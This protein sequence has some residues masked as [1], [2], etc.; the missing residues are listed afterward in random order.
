[1]SQRL[2]RVNELLKREI[3]ACIE[4]SFEF[5]NILVTVHAVETGKD[6]KAAT[7]FIGVIGGQGEADRVI[8]KLNAKRG[9]IQGVVMKRVVLRNTPKLTF[10]ADDSVERGVRVLNI[11]EELGDMDLENSDESPDN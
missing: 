3:S 7:V 8:S 5:T 10:V 11:L 4:K 2:D 1:M 9:F 6:L